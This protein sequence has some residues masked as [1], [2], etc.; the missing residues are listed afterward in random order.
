[1]RGVQNYAAAFFFVAVCTIAFGQSTVSTIRGSVTDPSG[2]AIAG[3]RIEVTDVQTNIRR[4]VPSTPAGEFEIPDLPQSTYRLTATSAG[5]K[6]FVAENIILE[7]SQIRRIDVVF[8]LGAV[9]SEVTVKADAAVIT[10]D[11]AKI[12]SSFTNKRFEDAPWVGDG[13]NPQIVMTTLPLVQSSGGIYSIQLAGLPNSQVQTGIDGVPGDG[14][15][16]QASNI[17][18]MQEVQITTGNNSAE[19]SRAAF[20]SLTTK[21]GTNSF[22]GRAAYWHQN[23]ALSARGFFDA[24]KAKNLFHTM[25]AQLAGPI[26]KDHTF[27]FGSWSGQRWPSSTFYLRDVPTA[28]MRQGDFSQ[29]LTI[30]R[31]VTIKD[32]LTGNPFPGNIIPAN[33]LNATSLK[34]QDKY[35]PAPNLAGPD[36]LANNFGFL[37]PHP[38]DLFRWDSY[39][40]RIDHRFN[41]KNTIS[42]HYLTSKPLYVLAG[43]FPAFTWTRIRDSRTL[44]LCVINSN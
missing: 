29:L 4:S 20:I 38:T 28:K 25:D 15:S 27:F 35:L 14:S 8:E 36:A 32:P 31:P 40:I 13:R 44:V 19:Y 22:H 17:H 23:S 39:E 33:R 42:G 12:A 11:T 26:R 24:K 16:L 3:A 1:M 10:T 30:S 43:T 5:F 34:I 6:T 2:A 7:S 37:F 41:D 18:V 9:G 21:S